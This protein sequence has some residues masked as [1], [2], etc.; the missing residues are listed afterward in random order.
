MADMEYKLELV[1]Y[2][3]SVRIRIPIDIDVSFLQSNYTT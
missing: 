1:T 2:R 3:S